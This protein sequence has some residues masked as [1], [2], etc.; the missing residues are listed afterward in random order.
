MGRVVATA[1][2]ATAIETFDFFIYTTASALVFGTLFFPSFS[3]VAGTLAAFATLAV[4]FVARPI[5]GVVAGHLGDRIGRKPVLIG[6]MV[7]M[8]GATMLIGLL[9]TYAQI[10]VWAPVVLIVLRL[11]QGFGLGA[12]WGGAALLLTEHAPPHRRGFFGSFTQVGGILG[13]AAGNLAFFIV[14]STMSTESFE[15]WG[16]R[17]PFLTGVLLIVVCFYLNRR[18]EETPV[19]RELSDGRNDA[20]APRS[21]PLSEVLRTHKRTVLLAAGAYLVVNAAY[22]V[23]AAGILTYGTT[24]LGFTSSEILL[25]ALC[26]GGTQLITIPLAGLLS[27]R[28][29]RRPVYLTGAALMGA[30]AI[31]MFLLIDTA[32]AWLVFLALLVGFTLHSLMYGPQAALYAEL[33][34]AEVRYSGAS[35]GY[36]LATIFAGGLAPFIMTSLLAATG[37]SWTVGLYLLGLA[38]LTFASVYAMSETSRR[39]LFAGDDRARTTSG[40]G[41]AAT[42]EAR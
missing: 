38:V 8:G 14:L 37:A 24:T 17:L 29:G 9:P 30:W 2:T 3:P 12:Q 34:P 13:A 21:S 10:G 33:F 22:Y 41:V 40:D 32:N 39:S 5:G 15:S 6:A 1:V 28:V 4:G 27:D 23:M 42:E 16:W 20:P 31:P 11:A 25:I 7:V 26:A 36:Q 18:I 19:F 35:L